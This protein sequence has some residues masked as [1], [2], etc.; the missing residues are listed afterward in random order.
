MGRS[1]QQFA[2]RWPANSH[3]PPRDERLDTSGMWGKFLMV[4]IFGRF[5]AIGASCWWWVGGRIP[6]VEYC[7]SGVECC[8]SGVIY[9]VCRVSW[10]RGRMRRQFRFLDRDTLYRWVVASTHSSMQAFWVLH[11]LVSLEKHIRYYNLRLSITLL[12]YSECYK[13]ATEIKKDAGVELSYILLI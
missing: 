12:G 4:Y 3:R 5:A 2:A 6:W 11:I 1:L 7:G 10:V 13:P 9:V 8:R